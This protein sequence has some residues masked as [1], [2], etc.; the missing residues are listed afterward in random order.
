MRLPFVPVCGG[1]IL[2]S[3]SGAH[4]FILDLTLHKSVTV[5]LTTNSVRVARVLL[6]REVAMILSN[7][8]Q[9]TDNSSP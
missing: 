6:A 8:G 3:T 9:C 1:H 2:W 7:A 4:G 5:D